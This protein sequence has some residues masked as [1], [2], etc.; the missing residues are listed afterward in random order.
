MDF[1]DPAIRFLQHYDLIRICPTCGSIWI[2]SESDRAAW[3]DGKATAC[4]NCNAL[5]RLPPLV[6][7]GE[8]G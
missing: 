4:L 5:H 6:T 1:D 8:N 7:E 3:A 2:V